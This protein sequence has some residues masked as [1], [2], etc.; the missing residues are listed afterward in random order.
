MWAAAQRPCPLLRVLLCSG[1][2]KVTDL[3]EQSTPSFSR[4]EAGKSQVKSGPVGKQGWNVAGKTKTRLCHSWV[5][6]QQRIP[7]YRTWCHPQ[8]LLPSSPRASCLTQAWAHSFYKRPGNKHFWLRGQ[9]VSVAIPQ[10][11]PTCTCPPPLHKPGLRPEWAHRLLSAN[12]YLT[13]HRP[14]HFTF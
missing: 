5:S 13:N 1:E 4:E 8:I 14:V 6:T 12:S 11:A 7:M 3:E 9:K 10:S 2:T